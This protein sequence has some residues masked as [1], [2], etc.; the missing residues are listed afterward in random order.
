[1]DITISIMLLALSC[2]FTVL[3]YFINKDQEI[4]EAFTITFCII[5]IAFWII[6]GISFVDLSSTYTHVV[7]DVIT[8]H[9][10]VYANSWLLILPVSM[11]GSAFPF[12]LIL[13]KVWETWGF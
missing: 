12:F 9:T 6:A 7:S 5:S 2:F 3:L 4:S 11:L 8:E 10:V 13:K 1:M